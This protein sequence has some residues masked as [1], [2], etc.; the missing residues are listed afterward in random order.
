MKRRLTAVT[1][2]VATLVATGGILLA[3]G[4]ALAAAPSYQPDPNSLGTLTFYD[5]TGHVITGGSIPSD[6]TTTQAM[7][8]YIVGSTNIHGTDTKGTLFFATPNPP[9]DPSTWTKQIVNAATTFNPQPSGLPTPLAGAGTPLVVGQ[10]SD[11]SLYQYTDPMDGFPST[12]TGA[13]QDI[14][15]VR[16]YTSS[17]TAAGATYNSADVHV[18][19]VA[20]TWNLVYPTVTGTTTTLTAS[21]ASPQVNGT[22]FHLHAAV[23]PST[24]P[25]KVVFTNTD[26]STV[27]GTVAVSSGAADSPDITQTNGAHH[28]SATFYPT[29]GYTDGTKAANT[30]NEYQDSSNALTDTGVPP[31]DGTSTT[32]GT[33]HGATVVDD[34]TATATVADT[35]TPA[36]VPTGTVQFQYEV[37]TDG[38]TTY[39]SPANLGSPAT[40]NGSGV[41]A[42]H[43]ASGLPHPS[44]SGPFTYIIL[45]SYGGVSGTFSPSSNQSAPFTL[46]A[47]TSD[48]G[49]GDSTH[50][51]APGYS[52]TDQ[53]N[54]D[55]VIPAGALTISTPYNGSSVFHLGTLHLTSDSHEF[56]TADPSTGLGV[57]FPATGDAPITITDTRPGQ[58][59]PWNANALCSQLVSGGNAIDAQNVGLTGPWTASGGTSGFDASSA[60]LTTSDNP[61][62]EPAVQPGASGSQGLGGTTPHL[63]AHAAKGLGTLTLRGYLNLN[64]PTNTAAGT[65]TGTITFTVG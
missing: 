2:G 27:V 18:D 33:T 50:A 46:T 26:T 7:A 34:F 19:R 60:N 51:A 23:T 10:S 30:L 36:T 52:C 14:Y 28:Y 20:H 31:A 62:A 29:P 58:P 4:P 21:P 57:A 13:L 64:A 11:A 32:V 65:Y 9:A 16:M 45:A 37:S 61:S 38:G 41:A 39:S 48:P 1:T 5:A 8:A 53:Q 12:Q 43:S 15:Q 40:L 24:V 47:P 55:A 54:I 44:G 56:T 22:T 63:F 3:A 59:I 25:G 6:T 42:Y 17:P 35:T 49:C